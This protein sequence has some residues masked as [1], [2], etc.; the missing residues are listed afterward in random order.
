MLQMTDPKPQEGKTCRFCAEIIPAKAKLCP[1]CRQWL[2]LRSFRN[3][4]FLIPVVFLPAI[5]VFILFEFGITQTLNKLTNPPP[6]Y[7]DFRGSLRILESKMSWADTTDGQRV[8]ITGI[9]TN[10]SPMAWR[11][12][13]F[14]TRFFDSKGQMI[15]AANGYTGFTILPGND[16]AFRVSVKPVLST[17]HY[18]SFKISVSNARS[19][20]GAF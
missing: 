12:L 18:S 3:P 10:Q 8:F 6:Y 11:G 9:V 15:D 17:N 7:S 1:R 19:T 2:Y 16:S 4:F 20:R 5:A 14:E 13:E